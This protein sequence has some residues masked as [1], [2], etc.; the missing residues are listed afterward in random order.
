[1]PVCII[2]WVR[3]DFQTDDGDPEEI[4]FEF[5]VKNLLFPSAIEAGSVFPISSPKPYRAKLVACE[6]PTVQ[7]NINKI[8]PFIFF[9]MSNL[10]L[11]FYHHQQHHK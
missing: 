6:N 4:C 11:F 1:M 8:R 2:K 10:I 5:P 3:E 9:C 7:N